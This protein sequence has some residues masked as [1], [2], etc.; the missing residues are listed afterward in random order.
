M[1]PRV[2]VAHLR[3]PET[4]RDR[5]SGRVDAMIRFLIDAGWAVTFLAA[6]DGP[7]PRH[8]ARLRQLGVAAHAGPDT[9]VDVVRDGDFDLA[10]VSFWE[11]AATLIPIL[12]EHSPRTRIIVDSHDVHFL[13]E[14]RR[15]FGLAGRIDASVGTTMVAELNTYR[16]ADA[17]LAVS[18][19]EAAL[20]GDFLGADRVHDIT[21]GEA[22]SRSP[23]PFEQ[24]RGLL[25]VGNFRHLPNGE[26]VEYLCKDVLPRLDPALLAAH[27]LTVIGNR[28]DAKIRGFAHGLPGVQMVGWVPSVE[29]YLCRARV[30]VAPLLHGAGVKG[31]VIEAMMTGTPVVTTPIGA[32]GLDLVAGV[33]A[34]VCSDPADIAAAITRL[35][36]DGQAW[37]RMAAAARDAVAPAQDLA[38]VRARFERILS[39][40][41]STPAPG[42]DGFR[43]GRTRLEAY[44]AGVASARASMRTSAD[45]GSVVLVAS[46]GD[47]DLLALEGRIGVHFPQDRDG[48]WAGYHPVDS[49]S[50]IR[51]L[52]A[53]REQGA[54]YFALPSG[55]FWW[56]HFYGKLAR[57]LE[58]RYRRVHSDG[59]AIVYDLRT[60]RSAVLPADVDD[61]PTVLV[62]GTY[63][64]GQ[65]GPKPS[66]AGELDRSTRFTV[67]QH[68]QPIGSPPHPAGDA[69][70]I[71]HVDDMADLPS[72]FLDDFLAVQQQADAERAQPAHD[73]GPDAASPICERLRGS[74][75]RLVT[76][77]LPL[78]VRSIRAGAGEDGTVLLVD[79]VPIRL[80]APVGAT[81][82]VEVVDVLAV[83]GLTSQVRARR[84]PRS[85]RISV[86]I[87]TYDR[88]ELLAG[89]LSSFAEQTLP[90]SDFEV[91]V[92]DDGSPGPATGEVLDR[93]RRRVPLTSS[94]LDHAGRSAAKNLAVMLARADVVLFFD[95]DDRAA[96]DL[97]AEHLRMHD[98]HADDQ[99]AVLGYTEWAPELTIT[100]FMHWVTDVDKLLFA[101]GNLT[102]GA[103]LDWR[104]FWE[105]RISCKRA[106]L[107]RAGLHDQR[108]NY[109]IDV[110]LAWRLA[111]Q[112]LK[113]VYHAA[114]RSVM[115]RD[116]DL[117]GFCTRTEGK[118]QAQVIMAA[119]HD[120]AELRGYAK[121][122]GVQQRWDEARP[123]LAASL[124]R[125]CA[126]EAA[127]EIGPELHRLY[128]QTVG[129]FFAK[130][131]AEALGAPQTELPQPRPVAVEVSSQALAHDVDTR[132]SA[133]PK[134]T[135][136]A[137]RRINPPQLTVTIPVWSRTPE[138]ADM[139]VR[140][141]ERIRDLAGM[142]TE[143]VVIDNGSPRERELAADVY[144][145]DT[146][147]GVAVAWNAGIALA[148]APVVAVLNSDCIVEA[149][150]DEAL[151]EAATDGRR[152]AF[153]Y[154][155]HADGQG[156]RPPDQGGTAGWC[157][158]ATAELF[159]EIGPF[160]EQFSPAF[161]EDTDYWHRAWQVGVDLSPV[162]AARVSHAR[163]TTGRTDP[164]VEWLLT[165]HRYKYGWKHGVEPMAAPPYYNRQIVEYVGTRARPTAAT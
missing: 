156:F 159:A 123:R 114:A 91:V 158:M 64:P 129:D 109:S 100:P 77:W 121:V 53:L 19:K 5:G 147:R 78:P 111:R 22:A 56:L 9:A 49:E 33:H 118:G 151:Y 50:A 103:H 16:A 92:V 80:A 25:F 135:R 32:E 68:W 160:D 143:I 52:E 149:G 72:G 46:H 128:R 153:P 1:K 127:G 74:A 116:I 48:G 139:A 165:S 138:L 54:G 6:E 94:H 89:C 83:D 18:A 117:R 20:L 101:Y 51:H 60:T 141:V 124:A 43:H 113:V 107:M 93:F 31:K 146:N 42:V 61:R 84:R 67:R 126:L 97:L 29:P 155:D 131:A 133:L 14:A 161:C 162:P 136:A 21:L 27:P 87:S 99:I 66:V 65:P 145:Y 3:M 132:G 104:G 96:P 95:D 85:P 8:A 152:I 45:P 102:D 15:W 115:A 154:T 38:A 26:A 41:L 37:Q 4:D 81:S 13:R 23:I 47:D 105:G 134:Q 120:D 108:M 163:R 112:G 79:H 90:A 62:L 69:D 148:G 110:E 157:F 36:V 63:A 142:A 17:V 2:L 58:E 12:R 24:R 88:P 35:L 164:H 11:V 144:R 125:A 71:L 75:A 70:Y 98:L 59:D 7:D 44:R 130:G 39:S 10:L 40:V 86:L 137:R 73:S 106:L 55:Q 122:D 82:T 28:L 140:T 57:H 34:M 150:W 30:A 119:L 76:G